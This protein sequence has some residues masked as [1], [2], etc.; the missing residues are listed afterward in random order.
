[1]REPPFNHL[2]STSTESTLP[3]ILAQNYHFSIFADRQDNRTRGKTC[4]D[5]DFSILPNVPTPT[6]SR[7]PHLPI[8]LCQGKHHA[9]VASFCVAAHRCRNILLAFR[10]IIYPCCNGSVCTCTQTEKYYV[11]TDGQTVYLRDQ[12]TRT[13]SLA[14]PPIRKTPQGTSFTAPLHV[15]LTLHGPTIHL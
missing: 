6:I 10:K 7:P 9:R 5:H 1:M 12:M 8:I 3:R 13:P 4:R 14:N 15:I 2:D 11:L